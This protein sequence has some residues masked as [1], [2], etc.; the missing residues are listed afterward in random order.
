MATTRKCESGIWE[1][2]DEPV[3]EESNEN[4]SRNRRIPCKLCDLQLAD[5]GGTSN[6][7]NHLQVKGRLVKTAESAKNKEKQTVLN[8]GIL[9]VCSSQHPAAITKRVAAFVWP[10]AVQLTAHTLS[11][12]S[13][14]WWKLL[15]RD[16]VIFIRSY[17]NT[18]CRRQ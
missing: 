7:M 9:R 6:L 11:T 14:I 5:G 3:E 4:T 15:A 17:F 16:Y 1:C 10:I 18:V 12:L 8:H 13:S 2:F